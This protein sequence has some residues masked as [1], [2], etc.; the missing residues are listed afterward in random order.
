MG[1]HGDSGGAAA[2][3]AGAV[4]VRRLLAAAVFVLTGQREDRGFFPGPV[5]CGRRRYSQ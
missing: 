4:L 3:I 2:S 5:A 1:G